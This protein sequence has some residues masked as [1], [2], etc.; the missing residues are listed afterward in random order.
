MLPNREFARQTMKIIA[1]VFVAIMLVWIV[2]GSIAMVRSQRWITNIP[3]DDVMNNPPP[4]P[5][6]HFRG[7]NFPPQMLKSPTPAPP[8]GAIP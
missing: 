7:V 8:G 5:D 4:T 3:D 1:V 2:W 6:V